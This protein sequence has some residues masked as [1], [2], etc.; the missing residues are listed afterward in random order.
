MRDEVAVHFGDFWCN[1]FHLPWRIRAKKP[2]RLW[3]VTSERKNSILNTNN[4]HQNENK[5]KIYWKWLCWV[6]WPTSDCSRKV[7]QRHRRYGKMRASPSRDNFGRTHGILIR[8]IDVVFI[9]A[10]RCSVAYG[11]CGLVDSSCT[12]SGTTKNFKT[13]ASYTQGW[14]PTNAK[15]HALAQ[16]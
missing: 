13:R 14:R 4:S 5:V 16:W 15:Q 1:C 10:G 12:L 3:Q 7:F 9:F 6:N 8:I 2:S 11:W